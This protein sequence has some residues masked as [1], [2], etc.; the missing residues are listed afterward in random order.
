MKKISIR[1]IVDKIVTMFDDYNFNVNYDYQE[2]I[3]ALEEELEG[4]NIPNNNYIGYLV[5]KYTCGVFYTRN[6][7]YYLSYNDGGSRLV[8]WSK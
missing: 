7:G 5:A 4:V 3:E 2:F 6:Q 1:K 8:S